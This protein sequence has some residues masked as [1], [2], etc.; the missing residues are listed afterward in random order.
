LARIVS[1]KSLADEND[2][3]L[4]LNLLGLLFVRNPRFRERVRDFR[5][6][7]AKAVLNVALAN[8]AIWASQVKKAQDAGFMPKDAQTD[9]KSVK[10]SYNPAD[11]KVEVPNEDHIV[12]EMNTFDHILPLL[13]ERKWVLASAP[14]GSGGLVTCDHPVCLSWSEPDPKR[15]R[16]RPGL[17][18]KGTEVLFPLSSTLAMVGA[19]ELENGEYEFDE[20]QV[21]SANGTIILNAQRQIYAR[22]MEFSYQID[23]TK[24][25]RKP[26][27]L[28]E[29]ERFKGVS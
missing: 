12:T 5:E 19:F 1:V 3:T 29:D 28:I 6:R 21:A 8:P 13:F 16:L 9:Y 11:Y 27:E 15:G 14:E 26:G 10:E 7:V 4:L 17:K 22:S 23:Q 24:P 2:R 25:P 18:L 20:E